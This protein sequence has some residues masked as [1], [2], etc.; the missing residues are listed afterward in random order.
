MSLFFFGGGGGVA[1]VLLAALPESCLAVCEPLWCFFLGSLS[2]F[3]SSPL[4][5]VFPSVLVSGLDVLLAATVF[6]PAAGFAAGPVA[7]VVTPG[8]SG[9]AAIAVGRFVATTS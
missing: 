2:P 7:G 8:F 1:G 3:S 6:W 9:P 5:S 4:P